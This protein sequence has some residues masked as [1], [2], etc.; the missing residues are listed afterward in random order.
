MSER[1]AEEVE[2]IKKS[3]LFFVGLDKL[4]RGIK[5]YEGQGALVEQLLKDAFAKAQDL[6]FQEYT[7]KITPVGPMLYAEPLSEEGKNPDYLFQL[8]CD[9]VRE[10]SFLPTITKEEI[11]KLAL[12][13]YGEGRSEQD[14]YVTVLWKREFTSIRYYAVDTLGVQVD[15]QTDTDMLSAR[16]EQLASSAE[17]AELTLSSSDLRLLRSEDSLSWVQKCKAPAEATGT[18][19]KLSE[20]LQVEDPNALKRFVAISL[21]VAQ[22]NAQSSILLHNLW[23]AFLKKE[24]AHSTRL[25]LETLQQ[26]GAQ[27]PIAQQYI[28]EFFSGDI[29][30]LAPLIEKDKPLLLC[31]QNM[32]SIPNFD[33]ER[34]V[35][36]LKSMPIGASRDSLLESLSNAGAD[37]TAFY[38]DNLRSDKEEIVLD[39]IQA[40]GKIASPPALK[41]LGDALG[42]HVGQI[43]HAAITA[44]GDRFLPE[45]QRPLTRL[46]KDP[47]PDLRLSALKLL[48]QCT[49]RSFGSALLGVMQEADFIKRPLEEQEVFFQ[50]I[51]R[52]PNASTM[53]FLGEVLSDKNITRSTIVQ[54]RQLLV[55]ESLRGMQSD[56]AFSF[57]EKQSK[58]W[59]LAAAVKDAIKN[60]LQHRK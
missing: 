20:Q 38:L 26:L 51:A 28:K 24:D 30:I 4:V 18:I 6:F 29:S 58:N 13:F 11:L 46:L 9:G 37:M 21:E 50:E 23:E 34:L 53:A 52:F 27:L 56:D 3:G 19:K 8:Y 40:L 1:T 60:A 14:D 7:Y 22:E 10:L 44:M 33:R 36:L 12:T 57:L 25:M 5:L 17:G 42:H 41:A 55:V 48:N 49:D 45:A 43:R 54:Q 59:F 35:D 15:D 31:V 39:A 32:L 16:S 47:D 2:V